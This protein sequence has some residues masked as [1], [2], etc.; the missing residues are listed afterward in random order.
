[1]VTLIYVFM[2][3]VGALEMPTIRFPVYSFYNKLLEPWRDVFCSTAD[4]F[5]NLFIIY[6][7]VS[8][9][10]SLVLL[11]LSRYFRRLWYLM[12]IANI[13]LGIIVLGL[14][15]FAFNQILLAQS[16]GGLF[17]YNNPEY[18]LFL[19]LSDIIGALLLIFIERVV[20][21][22]FYPRPAF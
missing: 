9:I 20:Y 1:M 18:F 8:I 12:R 2:L 15:N 17:S 4:I 11:L 3:I 6:L 7:V 13:I 16:R 10:L 22:K 14:A 21:K 19:L 5:I